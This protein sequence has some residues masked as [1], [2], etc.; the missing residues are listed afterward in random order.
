M[1]TLH[2]E[3]GTEFYYITKKGY[4]T[5][6]MYVPKEAVEHTRANI[7][8]ALNHLNESIKARRKTMKD[9][10]VKQP[11]KFELIGD[12]ECISDIIAVLTLLES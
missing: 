6:F 2:S 4:G 10:T 3:I 7:Q 5:Y 12:V 11:E 9:T 8:M 1:I